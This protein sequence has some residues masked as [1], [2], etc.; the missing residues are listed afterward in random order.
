[1]PRGGVYLIWL[2]AL[3]IAAG[4]VALLPGSVPGLMQ[5]AAGTVLMVAVRGSAAYDAARNN[6]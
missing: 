3:L 6:P 4:L 5:L 1:M 2:T